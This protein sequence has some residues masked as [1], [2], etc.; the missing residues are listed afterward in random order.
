[1]TSLRVSP[2]QLNALGG[3]V[4]RTGAEVQGA[5][6]ALRRELTPLLGS[7]WSG[8]A[9]LRFTQ[10]IEQFD[11]HAQGFVAALDGIGQL[12]NRAGAAYGEVEQQIAASFG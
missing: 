4:G 10:L 6:Q 3:S 7:D 1:M 8:A 11:Q 5:Y 2:E 9:A 12:L